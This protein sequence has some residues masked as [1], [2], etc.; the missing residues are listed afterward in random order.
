MAL[1]KRRILSSSV[2]TQNGE[3]MKNK[4]SSYLLLVLLLIVS[5]ACSFI[6]LPGSQKLETGSTQTF[7]LKEL[8]KDTTSVQDV[9]I[10]MAIGEF[11]LSGGSA[12]LIEGE[13]RY[14]VKEWKPTI[15]NKDNSLTISQGEPDFKVGGYPGDDVVNIWNLKLGDIPMNLSLRA[16]AY[17]A[18]LDLS[19]LPIQNLSIR[20]GVSD[21]KIHFNSLNPEVMQT[22]TYH[23]GGSEITFLGL[24]NAN[25]TRMDFEGGAG[26]Y[27]FDFSGNLQQ[28]ANVKI[29][30]GF[31][32][33][34]IVVPEGVSADVYVDEGFGNVNAGDAWIKTSSHYEN[35]GNG[36]QLTIVVEMGAGSLELKNK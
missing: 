14:N 15:T 12:S 21:S 1:W 19:G 26:T 3:N 35:K 18:S 11:A 6:N 2:P 17:N 33:V 34:K 13:V 9:N 4:R 36:P 5:L 27:T 25:F 29:K 8:S 10:S 30:V 24:A 16:G 7:T 28:D 32:N 31:S 20:D 23:T 22:L